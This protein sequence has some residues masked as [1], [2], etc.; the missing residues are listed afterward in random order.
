M[1][2]GP[3]AAGSISGRV[4]DANTGEGIPYAS[5][6]VDSLR[7]GGVT[8]VRGEY[9]LTDVPSGSH[10]VGAQLIGYKAVVVEVEVVGSTGGVD[11]D[12]VA[13]VLETG[14]ILVEAD[15]ITSPALEIAPGRVVLRESD[16]RAAP[17]LVE[18]D[19]VRVFKTLPGVLSLSD[20]SVGLYV[21][22]G[23]PD[24]NLIL[25]DGANLYNVSHLFGLFS[26]FPSDAVR[27]AELLK[28]GFPANYGGRLSSVLSIETHDGNKDR[29]QGSGGISL[30]SSRLALQGPLGS[31]SWMIAARRTYLEPILAI[32]SEFN[33]DLSAFGYHFY[34]VVGKVVQP[35]SN[36]SQAV[37]SWYVGEDD[38][39]YDQPTFSAGLKWGN[40]VLGGT[41]TQVMG[42]DLHAHFR[43]TASRFASRLDLALEDLAV[44]ERNTILD[45][46][47]ETEFTY[48]VGDEHR[49]DV[50]A[51]ANRHSTDY[52]AVFD[53]DRPF[54]EFRSATTLA[55]AY[56]QDSWSPW[57]FFSLQP[58]LRLSHTSNGSYWD[59]NPRL[60]SRLLL[61]PN[62]YIKAAVGRYTQHVFRVAREFQGLSFLSDLWFGSDTTSAPSHAWH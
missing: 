11:F 30:I 50:G 51:R 12:L 38:L 8:D 46:A 62:T 18:A 59:L 6:Y 15:R 29:L 52:S 26:M 20:F 57:P 10:L 36:H 39:E 3:A 22:G 7:V 56:A 58:G 19:P 55:S 54:N 5:V 17:M 49:I 9:R 28:G 61:A 27:S 40:R 32:A 23:T 1:L 43:A 42:V 21:R 16:F 41:W 2:A 35:V 14:T 13:D 33:D 53:G 47:G 31:G 37:V 48:F 60:A 34:D 24:Q 25:V 45:F 4:A 44:V